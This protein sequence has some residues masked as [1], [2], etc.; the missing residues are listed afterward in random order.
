MS[1]NKLLSRIIASGRAVQ[2]AQRSNTVGTPQDNSYGIASD[3][4]LHLAII[5]SAL[6]HDVDHSGVPNNVL[7]N[8][9]AEIA[10][11]YRERSVAEQNSVDLA[12]KLLMQDSFK[13]LR[14]AICCNR[15]E[16]KRFRE[17]VV[18]TVM[19]TG[20]Q[21]KSYPAFRIELIGQSCMP[22]FSNSSCH[23]LLT[24]QILLT[25]N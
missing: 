1:V 4:L 21:I 3:P 19:A 6:I 15:T 10:T 20:K 8:E 7:V 25:E 12:W 5:F 11:L 16:L 13:D 2:Q 24:L 18:V 14:R 23:C 9:K 17:L 22:S